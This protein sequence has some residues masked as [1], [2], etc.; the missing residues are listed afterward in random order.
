[1][2]RLDVDYPYASR[3]KSYLYVALGIKN[4]KS[5]D[6]LRNA[7]V[8]KEL[9]TLAIRKKGIVK[10]AKYAEQ[11]EYMQDFIPSESFNEKLAARGI[12]IFMFIERKWCCPISNSPSAWR[13]TQDNVAL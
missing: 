8:D 13:K 2:L 6:Y 11:H 5:K 1:M 10:I 9:D 4:R 12:D 3:A 7:E